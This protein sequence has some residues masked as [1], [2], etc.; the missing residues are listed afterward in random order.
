M[1]I[2]ICIDIFFK[3]CILAPTLLSHSH[4]NLQLAA[5]APWRRAC[6]PCAPCGAWQ[7]WWDGLDGFPAERSMAAKSYDSWGVFLG[8]WGE[9]DFSKWMGMV[10]VWRI[11]NPGSGNIEELWL[12]RNRTTWVWGLWDGLLGMGQDLLFHTIPIFGGERP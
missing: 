1:Y 12:K 2:Y 6:A 7:S 10:I 9:N 4:F 3:T 11:R 8:D 5:S